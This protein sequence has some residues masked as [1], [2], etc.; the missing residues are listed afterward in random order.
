[1]FKNADPTTDRTVRHLR[2]VRSLRMMPQNTLPPNRLD[3]VRPIPL[4]APAILQLGLL[5]ELQRKDSSLS[6]HGAIV[7]TVP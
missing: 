1:M 6:N 5:A 3:S 4:G 7:D 2:L